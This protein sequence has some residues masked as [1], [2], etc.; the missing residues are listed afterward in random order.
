MVAR[1]CWRRALRALRVAGRGY[2]VV[3]GQTLQRYASLIALPNVTSALFREVLLEFR[4]DIRDRMR[5]G[6][7][8]ADR[9]RALRAWNGLFLPVGDGP[10][11]PPLPMK[12]SSSPL[13][14]SSESAQTGVRASSIVPFP[15]KRRE[16]ETACHRGRTRGHSRLARSR[17]R[18][19]SHCEQDGEIKQLLLCDPGC[20]GR[21]R[22]PSGRGGT[23]R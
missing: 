16:E 7:V 2:S 13:F 21:S 5:S 3:S 22:C 17:L 4:G 23:R 19:F 9:E 15:E 18:R 1:R 8:E 6:V 12:A 10:K 11:L 20:L 14:S